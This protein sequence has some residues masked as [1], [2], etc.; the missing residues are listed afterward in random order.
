MKNTRSSE[1]YQFSNIRSQN[2]NEILEDYVEAI[3][4]IL[5]NKGDVKNADLAQHFGVSQATVNKNLKRL[6]NFKLVRKHIFHM[7]FI[8][9]KPG[10]PLFCK[11]TI[12]ISNDRKGKPIFTGLA[13]DTHNDETKIK[14]FLNVGTQKDW[15]IKTKLNV[16][17]EN[18]GHT[19]IA[20]LKFMVMLMITVPL[21]IE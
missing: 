14:M 6:I 1:P 7:S 21:L 4:E 3:Q 17:T 15:I 16:R 5:Q 9:S 2:K 12:A 19:N 13:I 11:P 18:S 20:V 10:L 8:Q